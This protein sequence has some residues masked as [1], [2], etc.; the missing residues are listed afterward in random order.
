MNRIN[1]YILLLAL[2]AAIVFTW[3]GS[4]E[5][6]TSAHSP[7]EFIQEAE[8]ARAERGQDSQSDAKTATDQ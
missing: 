2:I 8:K 7:V 5:R 1:F 6:P 3:F 4:G